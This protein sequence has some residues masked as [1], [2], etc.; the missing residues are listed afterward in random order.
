MSNF[1][2]D[3][4]KVPGTGGNYVKLEQGETKIRILSS[5]LLGW[6]DWDN[7]KPVRFPIDHKPQPIDPEKPIKHF[8]AMIVWNYNIEQIQVFCVTQKT[9]QNAITAYAK[10]PDWDSPLKYDIKIMR[11]GEGFDTEYSV[12]ALPHKEVNAKIKKAFMDKPCQ[13]EALF[14]NADPFDIS[15]I[16]EVK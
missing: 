12:I 11:E 15:W 5:P 8:W 6:E 10:D 1:L 3:N 16:K 4:Y 9:I 2:P 14:C 13:L 7:K